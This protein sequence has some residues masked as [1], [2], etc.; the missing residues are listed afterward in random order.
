MSPTAA[1]KSRT[2]SP[3][4]VSL[5]LRIVKP[6]SSNTSVWPI[7]QQN[8]IALERHRLRCSVAIV[9]TGV[10]AKTF[11]FDQ[12]RSD[13][14]PLE[15]LAL[16]GAAI[17]TGLPPCEKQGLDL[18]PR[19]AGAQRLPQIDPFCR[20]EAQ[21]PHAVGREPAPVAGGAEGRRRGC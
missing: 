9:E 4:I 16:F 8:P 2:H 14:D 10:L 6:A 11:D 12:P 20:V 19:S 5:K 21:K 13:S 3:D 15:L 1:S 18:I 17:P 7:P